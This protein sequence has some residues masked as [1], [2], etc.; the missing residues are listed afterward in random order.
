VNTVFPDVDERAMV[1]D[2]AISEQSRQQRERMVGEDLIDK[3][4]LPLQGF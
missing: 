3:R 2:A 1:V 4:L